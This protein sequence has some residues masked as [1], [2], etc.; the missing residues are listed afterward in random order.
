MHIFGSVKGA[1][2]GCLDR[3]ISCVSGL[4][5]INEVVMGLYGIGGCTGGVCLW[6]F[7]PHHLILSSSPSPH[8]CDTHIL[9]RLVA[10]MPYWVI[11]NTEVIFKLFFMHVR[12]DVTKN[13]EQDITRDRQDFEA[14]RLDNLYG[15]YYTSTNGNVC[16]PA[17]V[18]NVCKAASLCSDVL[19]RHL[20]IPLFH[21][22][23]ILYTVQLYSP[24]GT[25][26]IQWVCRIE[27]V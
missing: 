20:S 26:S 13:K 2:P 9:P 17:Y 19:I 6:N 7:G 14:C 3:V 16:C 11:P 10:N 12:R 5:G 24:S 27:M 25:A 4:S 18:Y 8:F 21:V 1:K 15:R 23:P 22:P